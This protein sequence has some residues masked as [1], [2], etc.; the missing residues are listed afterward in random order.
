MS[1]ARILV[2]RLTLALLVPASMAWYVSE[3]F[4]SGNSTQSHAHV[5][6]PALAAGAIL[7]SS[8]LVKLVTAPISDALAVEPARRD[9]RAR[10]RAAA[11]ALRLPSRLTVGVLLIVGSAGAYDVVSDARLDVP[12]DL[13]A[14]AAGVA[15]AITLLSGTLAYCVAAI[16]AAPLLVELG[17]APVRERHSVRS[18]LMLAGGALVCVP[19][20]LVFSPSYARYRLDLDQ[21]YIA[22]TRAVLDRAAEWLP[23]HG[24]S[25]AVEMVYGSTGASVAVVGAGGAVLASAGGGVE[26]L[27]A[28][29][30]VEGTGVQATSGGWRLW[31][32]AGGGRVLVGFVSDAPMLERR[33]ALWHQTAPLALSVL[34]A[35]AILVWLAARAIALPIHLLG[36]AATRIASGDL[37]AR[38]PSVTRDELGQL[39]ADFRGMAEGLAALVVEVQAESAGVQEG[40]RGIRDIGARVSGGA[41]E[42][43]AQLVAVQAA[44]EAMQRSVTTVG[45]G[46]QGL[47]D[48][49]HSTSAAV[50][51]MAAALHEVRR[52]ASELERRMEE[53]GDDVDRLSETGR[54]AQGRL[55]S[56]D[57]L[58]ERASGT[59]SAVSASLSGLETQAIG[60]QLAAAQA[61]EMAE[62]AGNVVRA[63]VDGIEKVRSAVADAK[64]HVTLL[65]RR[66]DDVEQIL[67]FVGEVAGR[68]NLLSLNASIIATQAGEHGKPFAVVA[69]QIRELASQIS[70]STK[71]IG[72]IIRAVRDDVAGTVRVIERVDEAAFDGVAHARKSLDALVRIRAATAQGHET[73]AS[74]LGAVQEHGRTTHDVAELVAAV[75]ENSRALSDAIQMIGKSVSAV[76]SVS[77]A[78][79]ELADKVGR[80][81]EE[82][83]G[84]GQRQLNS[85]DRIDAML[86]DVSRAVESHDGATRRV[87]EALGHL[88]RT[89]E[90]HEGAVAELAQLTDKL[91][92]RSRTLADRVNRFKI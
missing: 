60:G 85:L 68:T 56:L 72:E 16:T 55:Q 33:E 14:A 40:T 42:E 8:L 41:A 89:A 71:S 6:V 2:V 63:A 3:T 9:E 92:G 65:G 32:P 18:K 37:T 79:S 10:Q 67:D 61:A 57:G 20:L 76:G 19:I 29:G 70:S 83:S 48:Y 88:E 38:P 5:L 75:E 73:A 39:A 47:T 86:A 80:A 78:V 24:A 35:A 53:A 7:L 58:A 52:Q 84:L 13:L 1:F 74:I 11:A 44:V 81:L 69:D 87:L 50:S 26:E 64:A 15:L 43:H 27:L 82:Q 28:G 49:V 34:A 23:E 91:G 51:Q 30:S 36:G 77:R 22:A 45:K 46:L 31:R 59:V 90:R 25:A 54:K 62:D 21:Q 66:S 4:F 17:E 12:A